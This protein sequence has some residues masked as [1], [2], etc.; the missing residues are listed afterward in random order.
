MLADSAALSHRDNK[1]QLWIAGECGANM[2][3]RRAAAL[4]RQAPEHERS[5]GAAESERIRQRYI[6]RLLARLVRHEVDGGIHGWIVQVD[7]RRQHPVTHREQAEYRLDRTSGAEQM[8]DRRFRRR[9]RDVAGG[10]TDQ[11]LDGLELD[12]VAERRRRAMGVDIVDIARRYAGAADRGAHAPERA[13]AVLG[14]R[15]DVIGVAGK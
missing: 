15:G 12:L 5:I 14:R 8:T 4:L 13:I 3:K 11:S 7:G 2:A 1:I 10:V 9:H 6:D